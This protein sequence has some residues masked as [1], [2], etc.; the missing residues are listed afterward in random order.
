[1]GKLLKLF[2]SV[3]FLVDKLTRVRFAFL[4]VKDLK[5][6]EYRELSVKEVKQLYGLTK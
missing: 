4:D 3:G 2:E 5:S 1:M 6:G